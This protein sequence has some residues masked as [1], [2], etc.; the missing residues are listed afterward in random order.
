MMSVE[1]PRPTCSTMLTKT[2]KEISR[3]IIRRCVVDV[4]ISLILISRR[5]SSK[6]NFSSGSSSGAVSLVVM[7][8]FFKTFAE[9]ASSID[10]YS[11]SRLESHFV[12]PPLLLK[13]EG[14]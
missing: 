14:L 3:S 5:S 13:L 12:A 7:E 4:H 8:P 11:R 10:V 9:I 1:C 6:N 2:K